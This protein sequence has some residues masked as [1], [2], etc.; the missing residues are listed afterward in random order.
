[1]GNAFAKAFREESN[2]TETTNGMTCY[3][4][5]DSRVMDLFYNV[6]S[7]RKVSDDVIIRAFEEA[8]DEDP[9][10]ACRVMFYARNVRTSG[11]N[12]VPGIGERHVARVMYYYMATKNTGVMEEFLKRGTIQFFGRWDDMYEFIG[13][14]LESTAFDIMRKQFLSDIANMDG[15]KASVSLLGKWL[16][17][18][19]SKNEETKRLGQATAKAFNMSEKRY[20]AAL[21]K[22][23]RYIN[24]TESNM[25]KKEWGNID[26]SA[27]PGSAMLRYGKAFAR[28]DEE[29]YI[30][31]INS[32][33]KGE[34]KI[35][36]GA[37]TPGML[38]EKCWHENGEEVVKVISAQ[39]DALENYVD[40]DKNVL[41]MADTSGSMSGDPMYNSIGLAIYF[42]ERNKGVMHNMFM[43]FSEKPEFVE[44]RGNT[45]R[46]K[47][48]CSFKTINSNTN[49][50]LAFEKLLEMAKRKNIPAEEMPCS[51]VII[52]DMQF[53]GATSIYRGG[54]NVKYT[55]DATICEV[56]EKEYEENGYKMPNIVFWNASKEL[57]E[58][59]PVYDV[60]KPSVQM[61]CGDSP[62]VF[63][64]VI[65][66]IG[67]TPYEAMLDA[68][69]QGVYSEIVVK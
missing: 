43:T 50:Q 37:V 62:S 12:G 6:A 24:V 33:T 49:I 3:K 18:C 9:T 59:T 67:K 57:Y 34:S 31:Y 46:E 20:R 25:S 23:R 66:S 69:S 47:I 17:S 56:I 63:K 48:L 32:V 16:K 10:L 36:V 2:K 53:D 21:K 19:N 22:L 13:T 27:V 5:T 68:L 41:I 65:N 14:P 35:N 7:M 60:N 52:S 30:A 61:F 45:L 54:C 38:V 42:A 51:I 64:N 55:W 58:N 28:N 8:Y 1:M 4:S 44:L 29:R 40:S 39:W 11:K 15:G 26:Y